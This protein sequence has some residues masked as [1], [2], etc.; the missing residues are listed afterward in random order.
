[1]YD[2]A[3]VEDEELER[4]ALRT[5]LSNKI[6]GINIVGEARNGVEAMELI[7]NNA[8]DLILV[9]INIPKPQRSGNHPVAAAEEYEDQGCYSHC[10]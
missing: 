5:I 10:L 2:V 3:I 9:D 8:I 4:R 7:N 1:M 6:D